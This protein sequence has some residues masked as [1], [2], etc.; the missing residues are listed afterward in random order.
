MKRLLSILIS[1]ML[2]VMSIP[3]VGFAADVS[4]YAVGDNVAEGVVTNLSWKTSNTVTVEFDGTVDPATVNAT[5]VTLTEKGGIEAEVPMIIDATAEGATIKLGKLRPLTDYVLTFDGVEAVDG[6]FAKTEIALQSASTDILEY[7][8][9]N[10]GRGAQGKPEGYI[11]NTAVYNGADLF[12]G[13]CVRPQYDNHSEYTRAGSDGAQFYQLFRP[14]DGDL[15]DITFE[16]EMRVK[17]GEL[18][19]GGVNK[20]D[21]KYYSVMTPDSFTLFDY[22][23]SRTSTTFMKWRINFFRGSDGYYYGNGYILDSA[24]QKW[25]KVRDDDVKLLISGN[26]FTAFN[27]GLWWGDV[28]FLNL[29]TS[30]TQTIGSRKMTVSSM[31]ATEVMDFNAD[32]NAGKIYITFDQKMNTANSVIDIVNYDAE[33][34]EFT[35]AYNC[36]ITLDESVALNPNTEYEISLEDAVAD[37]GVIG[38]TSAYF[39]T[40]KSSKITVSAV[41][42][43]NAL[44]WTEANTVEIEFTGEIVPSSVTTETVTLTEKDGTVV[45]IPYVIDNVTAN[46]ATIKIGKLKALTDYTLTFDGVVPAD[47]SLTFTKSE[48]ALNSAATDIYD[49]WAGERGSFGKAPGAFTN[50][51]FDLVTNATKV[52]DGQGAESTYQ[53]YTTNG[54][55]NLYRP[56]A[57]PK[58]IGN[59]SEEYK[60]RVNTGGFD[61]AGARYGTSSSDY[62]AQIR[63]A[64]WTILGASGTITDGW[65]H[66]RVNFYRKADGFYYGSAYVKTT[67]NNETTWKKVAS[68]VLVTNEKTKTGIATIPAYDANDGKGP[69]W[70]SSFIGPNG[71][72]DNS[73]DFKKV[74]LNTLPATGVLDYELDLDNGKI[75]VMFDQKVDASTVNGIKLYPAGDSENAVEISAECTDGYNCIITIDEVLTPGTEYTVD[76]SA[77]KADGGAMGGTTFNFETEPADVEVTSMTIGDGLLTS[78]VTVK[79]N[80]EGSR[81]ITIIL[82]LYDGGNSLVKAAYLPKTVTEDTITYTD[83]AITG[84]TVQSGYKAK[85]MVWEGTIGDCTPICPALEK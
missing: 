50:S 55:L 45:D 23:V 21:N 71:T 5:T 75:Y 73:I 15:G 32:L 72:T 48:I 77:I 61:S 4:V 34:V 18:K 69:F 81:D 27:A 3:M 85:L 64:T 14:T 82:A 11:A 46:S 65:V 2:I 39:T 57:E 80:V 42:N 30:G 62:M 13:G 79:K 29:G 36:V 41:G 52:T 49:Y 20:W 68:D 60:V 10:G 19:T 56:T 1:V 24:T 12:S 37:S 47:N 28:C 59:F 70:V 78:S 84:V 25:T 38:G 66:Y 35:D 74:A 43:V 54:S 63:N 83:V 17:T 44:S 22:T 40:P 33:S 53:N 8:P 9:V 31:A 26:P 58:D 76:M 16:Y 51:N 7:W 67:E 6:E